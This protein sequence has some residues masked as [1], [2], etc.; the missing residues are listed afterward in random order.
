MSSLNWCRVIFAGAALGAGFQA[1]ADSTPSEVKA[2]T[3]SYDVDAAL[4][5]IDA[6]RRPDTG[7]IQ[8]TPAVA[9]V[10]QPRT[11]GLEY[12]KLGLDWR[13]V[14]GAAL[15]LVLRPDAANH[16]Q[17]GDAGAPVRELDSRSGAPYRPMPTVR[18]LDS[19]QLTVKPGTSLDLALGV[20]E[21]LLPSQAAYPEVL[22][23]GLDVRTP[24]KFSAVRVR[25]HRQDQGADT[26]E[27]NANGLHVDLYV[28]HG[29]DD[30]AEQQGG[31]KG[32]FDR[33]PVG[34]DPYY[35]GAAQFGWQ[36]SRRVEWN[37]LGGYGDAATC[38][39]T[40]PSGTGDRAALP[41]Q[42]RHPAR[43]Q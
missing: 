15:R 43:R 22:G 17:S 9:M 19:Y 13:T 12:L 36:P 33:A 20:F 34:Q 42:G 31:R 38:T 6:A 25:W 10:E 4:T 5:Y 24:A 30:R 37:L 8:A 14:E 1:F 40:R 28:L 3:L 23:F 2:T 39:S 29:D 16:A 7:A 21:S 41:L 11:L 32:S 27:G 18:L 26:L 35:G